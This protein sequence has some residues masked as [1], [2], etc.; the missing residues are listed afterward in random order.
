MKRYPVYWSTC[1]LLILA[2]I[3]FANATTI[4][5]PSD[6]ALVDKSRVIVTATVASTEP[7]ERDGKI[8]TE[9]ILSVERTFKGEV[10]ATIT[11]R[12]IGRTSSR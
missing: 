7:V 10:P 1:V 4:I 11:V 9:S 3:P 2:T 8:W 6:D 12:E 5:L